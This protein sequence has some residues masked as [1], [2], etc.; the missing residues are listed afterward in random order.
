MSALAE[1]EKRL[2]NTNSLIV[3]YE[4]ALRVPDNE[5]HKNA[6]LVSLHS[7]QKLH[8]RPEVEFLELAEEQIHGPL[9]KL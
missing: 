9:A 1:L 8:R 2:E 4:N 6:I 5:A 3:Q 7:L